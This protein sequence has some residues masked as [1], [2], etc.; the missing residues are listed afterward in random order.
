MAAFFR[1][2]GRSQVDR[3]PLGRQP[4]PDRAER[5]SDALPAFSHRLVRQSDNRKGGETGAD[6]HLNID[7]PRFDTQKCN[8]GNVGKHGAPFV[9]LDLHSSWNEV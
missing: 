2:I 6:L 5:G 7:G 1:E 3:Y 4:Q 8:R 9:W